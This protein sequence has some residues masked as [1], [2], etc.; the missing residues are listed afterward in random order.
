MKIKDLKC[1]DC[2]KLIPHGHV[3]VRDVRFGNEYLFYDFN[4]MNSVHSCPCDKDV[5]YV[6]ADSDSKK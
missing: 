4:D 2:F 5:I 3:Y 6:I 1:G